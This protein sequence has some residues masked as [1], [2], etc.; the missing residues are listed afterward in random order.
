MSEYTIL[1]VEDGD[2]Y[3]DL[4]ERFVPGFEYIQVQSGS[5]A[6]RA[7]NAGNVDLVYLDMCFDRT[8]RSKLL[9]D[10]HAMTTRHAGDE[11]R[12]WRFLE[13]NQGLFILDAIK[14]GA[15]V[16]LPILISHDFSGQPARWTHLSQQHPNLDWLSDTM[17]PQEINDALIK[18][19]KKHKTNIKT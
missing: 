15:S 17:S 3:L 1:V 12:G 19:I 9:G 7:L 6:L 16:D 8:P 11:E 18:A 13:R 14:T 4:L 5:D 10:H 2:E